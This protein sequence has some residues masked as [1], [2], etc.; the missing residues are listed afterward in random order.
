MTLLD[1]LKE[2]FAD[3]LIIQYRGAERNRN[4]IKFLVDLIF[5]NNL[6]LQIKENTVS[7]NSIGAQL[8]IVG[9]WVGVSR[10]YPTEVWD[11][12]FLAFPDYDT[13]KNS[14]YSQYQGGFSDYTTFNDNNGGFLMY[15]DW[16]NVRAKD[17]ELGDTLFKQLIE[18]KIIK[19]SIKHTCKN[20]DDAIWKWSKGNVYTTWG[21]PIYEPTVFYKLNNPTI[22]QNGIASDFDSSNY[23]YSNSTIDFS[24]PFRIIFNE[25]RGSANTF[26]GFCISPYNKLT[27]PF[28]FAQCP[29]PTNIT[30]GIYIYESL[31]KTEINNFVYSDYEDIDYIASWDGETYLLKIVDV[32]TNK[33][34]TTLSIKNT[35]PLQRNSTSLGK[36]IYG[37]NWNSGHSIQST[38][39]KKTIA[40]SDNQVVFGGSY[41]EPMHIVYHYKS[42]YSNII[43]IANYKGVLLKPLGC[44]IILEEIS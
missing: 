13:I 35:Q 1:E 27:H 36:I 34:I 22:T 14:S 20:I 41:D 44:N 17:N 11:R 3:L 21:V 7:L 30:F 40:I 2:Y 38:D 33:T 5:A 42:S 16:Q 31:I 18:L 10:T 39:L 6:A 8:D 43:T 24:K 15:E 9:K 26:N 28:L 23:F 12:V 32:K 25:K 37:Y 29:T 19:N 4:L